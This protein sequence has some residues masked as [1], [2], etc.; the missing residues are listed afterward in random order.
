MGLECY[1]LPGRKW[2]Y[3]PTVSVRNGETPS[4]KSKPYSFTSKEINIDEYELSEKSNEIVPNNVLLLTYS[5]EQRYNDILRLQSG[6]DISVKLRNHIISCLGEYTD[7]AE[8]VHTVV[9][10]KSNI[11]N[12][13]MPIDNSKFVQILSV[14]HPCLN[15]N[16]L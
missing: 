11:T 15:Q 12:K 16:G 4:S 10:H 7:A 13:Y 9:V 6:L 8:K 3:A 2:R 1:N 5:D 14:Q